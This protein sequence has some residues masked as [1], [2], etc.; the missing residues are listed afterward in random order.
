MSVPRMPSSTYIVFGRNTETSA[1]VMHMIEARQM[2]DAWGTPDTAA[3]LPFPEFTKYYLP[4]NTSWD[5]VIRR[6]QHC[7][8][9]CLLS[10]LVDLRDKFSLG[11]R[12]N[13]IDLEALAFSVVGSITET[14]FTRDAS[15]AIVCC[16][17]ELKTSDILQL[18]MY[19]CSKDVL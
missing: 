17:F 16:R 8:M 6:S 15:R 7:A 3:V 4:I 13:Q 5:P 12:S 9:L 2:P 1:R 19:R 18:T 14:A 11:H 10:S